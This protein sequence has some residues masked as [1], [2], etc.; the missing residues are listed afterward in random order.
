MFVLITHEPRA[1]NSELSKPRARKSAAWPH[2]L[3]PFAGLQFRGLGCGQFPIPVRLGAGG[4]GMQFTRFLGRCTTSSTRH[5]QYLFR[6]E[7]PGFHNHIMQQFAAG[8]M[9]NIA[10]HLLNFQ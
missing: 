3:L 10:Q 6:G 4:A 9:L 8:K 5:G 1:H 2:R 7:F